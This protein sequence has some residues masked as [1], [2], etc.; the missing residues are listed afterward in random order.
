[1]TQHSTP[2]PGQGAGW[3]GRGSTKPAS[4]QLIARFSVD[5]PDQPEIA[6]KLLRRYDEPHRH[7][8]DRRHLATILDWIDRLAE[9]R[10]DVFRVRLA[11]WFHDAIYAVV[12]A[13]LT[14]EEASARLALADLSRCGLE[15]EDL[16]EIARLIRLTA[17]HRA[18]SADS[19]GALL[20][21]ADLA[22][23]AAPQDGYR[24]YVADVRAEHSTASDEDFARGRFDVVANL[25]CRT[26]FHTPAG[27]E[28]EQDAHTNLVTEAYELLDWLGADGLTADDWPLNQRRPVAEVVLHPQLRRR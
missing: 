11:A 4:H 2:G 13:Q 22:I 3:P 1:M 5:L 28:L 17:T 16:N 7:Y 23:L 26:I 6:E 25:G 10:N 19:D 14:N 27:R 24:R 8:H 15:Q 18:N 9:G 21:D 12:P 20:C